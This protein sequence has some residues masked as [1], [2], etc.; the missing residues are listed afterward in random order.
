MI[1]GRKDREEEEEWR[2]KS[3]EE[4]PEKRARSEKKRKEKKEKEKLNKK[5]KEKKKKVDFF[6][7]ESLLV[8]EGAKWID[9]QFSC[10]AHRWHSIVE[11]GFTVVSRAP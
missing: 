1:K 9:S 6:V 5:R 4:K 11:M 7:G 10:R 3:N 8:S 2:G